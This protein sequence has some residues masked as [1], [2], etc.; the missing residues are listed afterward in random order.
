MNMKDIKDIKEILL[1][2]YISRSFY[3]YFSDLK[4]MS[5]NSTI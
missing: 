3:R 4:C 2:V 1:I 5:T